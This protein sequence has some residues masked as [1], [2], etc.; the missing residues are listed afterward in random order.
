MLTLEMAQ[1]VLG[2]ATNQ[3]VMNLVE[4]IRMKNS[5]EGLKQIQ[6]AL[7]AGTDPR[8]FA[9]QM[10]EYLRNLLLVQME[11]ASSVNA[12]AEIRMQMGQHAQAF[13]RSDLLRIIRGFNDAAVDLRSGWQASLPLEL[14]FAEALEQDVNSQSK[15]SAA[16]PF[17]AK[18]ET[19]NRI[20]IQ[21]EKLPETVSVSL[22]AQPAVIPVA[23]KEINLVA[24]ENNATAS[25]TTEATSVCR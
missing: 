7:D 23:E 10:V 19:N 3:A 24:S 6:Q 17:M 13:A 1:T 11:N 12:P 15:S 9:R 22:P 16:Q 2:T 8:Q 14:A 4:A 5:A 20:Q 21:N 25:A 18:P